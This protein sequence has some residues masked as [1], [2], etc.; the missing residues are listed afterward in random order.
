MPRRETILGVDL[1][2]A[3]SSAAAVID[4]RAHLVEDGFG[5]ACFPSVVY[6]PEKGEPIVGHEALRMRRSD[7]ANAISGIKRVLG[8]TRQSPE[9]R[10]FEAHN[11]CRVTRG[12]NDLPLISAHGVEHAPQEIASLILRSLRTRAETKFGAIRRIVLTIPAAL[13]EATRNATLLAAKMAGLEVIRLVPEPVAGA[14]ANGI[15]PST[16]RGTALVYDFG[17]GTFDATIL[18]QHGDLLVPLALGGD[19]CL[20]GDDFDYEIAKLV[21]ERVFADERIDITRDAIA[22]ERV[23][24]E[25]ERVKRALSSLEQAHLRIEDA[26]RAKSGGSQL[27]VRV[28]RREMEERWKDLVDR[29]LHV[30][31]ELMVSAGVRPEHM[32]AVLLVGGTTFMPM[33]RRSIE[34]V[35]G[36]AGQSRWDPQTAVAVGAAMIGAG[37]LRVPSREVEPEPLR[38]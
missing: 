24:Q 36:K 30:T 15:D 28:T 25:S 9:M 31:A 17:G 18:E 11:A 7:P 1:G 27:D 23:V 33:V 13:T 29:S 14:H 5:E 4:G 32:N 6:F 8:K 2:H 35:L 12:S 26:Y 34:R 20:G 37:S 21:S 3:F 10:L 22:W 16:M 38:A 19:T